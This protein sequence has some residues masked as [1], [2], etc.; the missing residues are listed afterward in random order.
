MFFIG[1]PQLCHQTNTNYTIAMKRN[2]TLLLLLGSAALFAQTNIKLEGTLFDQKTNQPLSEKTFVVEGLNIQAKTNEKGYYEISIPDDVYQIDVKVDGYQTITKT[3]TEETNL[4]MY[5]QPEDFKDG[6]IDLSTAVVTGVRSKS[7]ESNLLN[8]QK[9]STE[10]VERVGAAQLEKQGIG[11]VATAITKASGTIKQEGTGII[12]VRGLGDRFNSTTLNG[13]IIPSDDPENKNINLGIFKTNMVDYISLEKSFYPRMIG[14]FTGANID[15]VSKEYTGKAYVKIGVGSSVNLQTIDNNKFK[16]QDGPNFFG[17]KKIELPTSTNPVKQY[18]FKTNWDYKN[19]KNPFNTGIDLEAGGNVNIGREGKLSIYGYIGFDNHYAYREG[20]ENNVSAA[21]DYLKQLNVDRSSYTTNTNGLL[22]FI[23]RINSNNKI[24]LTSNT[25][26]ASEQ[27]FRILRGFLRDTAENG[28][29]LVH[30]ADN[31]VTTVFANQLFGEHQFGNNLTLNWG[32]AFNHINSE[33]PNRMQNTMMLDEK[34]NQYILISNSPGDNHRYYDEF[35]G[36]DFQGRADITKKWDRLKLT[37]GGYGLYKKRDFGAVQ[38]S[39]GTKNGQIVDPN[40]LDAFFNQNNFNN[41]MFTL[42]TLRG[43]GTSDLPNLLDPLS[44]TAEQKIYSGFANIEYEL[45]DK[46]LVQIGL[47][48]DNVNLMVDWNTNIGEMTGKVD[49]NYNKILPALNLKYSL[50]DNQNL[51]FSASKTYTLPQIKEMAPFA[52]DDVTN[53]TYGQPKIYP[54][55]NYNAELKWEFFPKRD[56]VLSIT[57]FGKYIKNPISRVNV[58][59]A[60]ANDLTYINT[61]DNGYVYGA[62]IEARKNIVEFSTTSKLY[63]ILNAAILNSN[64]KLDFEK[65]KNETGIATNFT[66]TDQEM[67][68]AARFSGNASLGYSTSLGGK[69]KLDAML[70]YGYVGKNV[71]AIGSQE[72]G[73]QML[74]AINLLDA[75]IRF[76]LSEKTTLSV[77]GKNLLNP[78]FTIEQN[79]R[80]TNYIL[81][82]YN[83]GIQVGLGFSHTL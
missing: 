82:N 16:Q 68:G 55:D 79:N 71:Y 57:A 7:A 67:V 61:G 12:F 27:D 30:R 60:S 48:N 35:S 8:M 56:E 36:N 22:N 64:Q 19:A 43:T 39:I 23:Y 38:I 59:S 34:I 78:N 31:K 66:K 9:K 17:F 54:S 4:N 70:V 41:G 26:H 21:G 14:D 63:T 81:E 24:T 2:L 65:V 50:T 45:S 42:S 40:N 13:F 53:T 10:I 75:N 6:K 32:G 15:I 73:S 44:Y 46:F 51:R 1:L 80:G 58:S 25:I 18:A 5:L 52:Y 29:G 33:R 62:E 47:R 28:Q 49:K 74:K 69:K 72:R 77:F 3:L 20:Q 83:R 37:V 76:N 11:D